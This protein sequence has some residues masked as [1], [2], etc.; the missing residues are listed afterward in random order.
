M[1]T[2]LQH[3][4]KALRYIWLLFPAV[5]FV[6]LVGVT[7]GSLSQGQDVLV[8]AA[9]NSTSATLF[10][11]SVSFF[12]L[13]CWYSSRIIVYINTYLNGENVPMWVDIFPR[14][15]GYFSFFGAEAAIINNPYFDSQHDA[16]WA[17]LLLLLQLGI[18][19]LIYFVFKKYTQYKKFSIWLIGI[20]LLIVS[21]CTF[22]LSDNGALNHNFTLLLINLWV[23]QTAFL[24]WTFFRAQKIKRDSGVI[25]WE[26]MKIFGLKIVLLPSTEIPFFKWFNIAMIVP[27]VLYLASIFSIP[28]S[29]VI[30]PFNI[31]LLCFSILVGFLHI[32]TMVSLWRKIN[33]HFLLFALAIIVGF[34]FSP[35][36]LRKTEVEQKVFNNR[37]TI[38]DYTAQWLSARKAEIE[39]TDTFNVYF[40]LS[41]GGASR[42]GYWVAGALGRLET[43]TGHNFSNRLFCLSGASGGSVGNAVYYSLLDTATY[44]ENIRKGDFSLMARNYLKSDFLSYTLSHLLG[45][46]YF[47]H[48][49]PFGLTVDRGAALEKSME[50]PDYNDTIGRLFAKRYSEYLKNFS[51]QQLP[52][53]Y[54]NT[55]RVADGKP[56]VISNIKLSNKYSSRIDVLAMMDTI[57]NNGNP[58]GDI[59]LSTAAVLSARFPYLSP[60]AD[61]NN[62]YFVDGG[63]FDNSGAGIVMETIAAMLDTAQYADSTVRLLKKLKFNIIHLSNSERTPLEPKR[64]H[65]LVND[66][67][68]PLLTLAGSYSQQTNVNNDRLRAFISTYANTNCIDCWTTVNLY[69]RDTAI[70]KDTNSFSM[71]WVISET[72]L[73]RMDERLLRN[74]NL[75]RLINQIKK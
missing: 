72:T 43:E 42:S 58:F 26:M 35:Y 16:L 20:A 6:L 34:F 50:N 17:S 1:T 29:R 70:D 67:A 44:D 64:M 59:H 62:M 45:P 23:V 28:T 38:T 25:R 14:I 19:L 4:S 61:I 75:N 46:D 21:V 74:Q 30:A 39:K 65:P 2:F 56:G 57:G 55:T 53:F 51:P 11:I 5:L 71:N 66:L 73:K 13:M 68:T 15:L 48:M 8:I 10:I 3:I 18:Y 31:V 60:A 32:I 54:I 63:Y 47:R 49:F 69:D 7:F 27:T 40:V 12:A 37:P 36:R 41:D 9:E 24:I 52:V 22:T 33:L